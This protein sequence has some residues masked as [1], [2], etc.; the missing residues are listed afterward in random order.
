MHKLRRRIVS[1]NPAKK[2]RL[3]HGCN[4]ALLGLLLCTTL[5]AGAHVAQEP[6]QNN[7]QRT[8]LLSYEGQKVSSVELAGQPDLNMD[9]VIPLVTQRAGEEFSEA[10]IEESLA[11]LQTKGKFESVQL[12]LRPE[13]DGVR[14]I[15][16]LQPAI[17][18]G[19]YQFPGAERFPYS[20][21]I[22][23]AN[24]VPQEPFSS[25][26]IQKARESLLVFLQ[27]NGY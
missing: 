3:L 10:K 23:A 9:E 26:D 15:F 11:A 22:L 20:R 5:L 19:M 6:T 8:E 18:F 21:L 12:D 7:I 1:N 2:A 17:Y 16:I 27:R 13:Q 24:Y 14:I 4:L 25:I